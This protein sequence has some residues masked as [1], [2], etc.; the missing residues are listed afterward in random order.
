MA[1]QQPKTNWAV[2]PRTPEGYYNGDWFELSDYSR[3]VGNLTWLKEFASQ[4][5][6]IQHFPDMT[7][8]PAGSP[9]YNSQIGALEQ[10]IQDLYTYTILPPEY[11]APKTWLDGGKLPT[12]VDMNRWENVCARYHKLYNNQFDRLP[13]LQCKLGGAEF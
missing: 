7:I 13:K 8:P 1:W 10:A 3:I 6:D 11:E 12:F 2:Q 4:M 9:V 5:Y